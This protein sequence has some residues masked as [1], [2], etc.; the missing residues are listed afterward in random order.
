MLYTF[1]HYYGQFQCIAGECEDTCCAGWEIMIDEASL[2]RYRKVKGAF[3]NRLYN[4]I[5]WKE[6]SF[7]Q[8]DNRCAFLNEE[9]LCDLYTELG[10]S[11]LCSTCRSYPRHLEQ[12]EGCREISLCLSCPEA[13]RIILGCEEKVRFISRSREGEETYEDFDFFLY[14]KLE[15]ARRLCIAFM[16]Q[17]DMDWRLRMSL[18]LGLAHDLQKRVDSGKLYEADKL[19]ERCKK[20]GIAQYA[21]KRLEAMDLKQCRYE[22]MKALFGLLDDMEP[23]KQQWPMYRD[24]L[25]KTLFGEGPE[26]YYENRRLFLE[27]PDSDRLPL[28]SEQLMVY[29]IFTYFLGSVYNE[30]PYGKMKL[31]AAS[32]LMIGEMAQALWIQKNSLSFADMVDAAH[33]FSREVEH[34]DDNKRLFEEGLSGQKFGLKALLGAVNEGGKEDWA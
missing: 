20:A 34:S 18:C 4:S 24:G 31:A 29:F 2:K 27:S 26:V 28:W 33:R 22:V 8:Y 6:G 13:A 21:K 11:A 15:D 32:V 1:P 25:V 10:P 9:N 17:R 23:L 14:T 30:N 3:G 16:Q 12:F 19:F 5:N 7:C